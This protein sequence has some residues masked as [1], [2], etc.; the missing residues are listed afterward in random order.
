MESL[1]Y[2]KLGGGWGP[3][4]KARNRKSERDLRLHPK[5]FF[6]NIDP[7]DQFLNEFPILKLDRLKS[8]A[9]LRQEEQEKHKAK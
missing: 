7:T 2:R 9:L 6:N 1:W 5:D 3:G 4:S 8:V